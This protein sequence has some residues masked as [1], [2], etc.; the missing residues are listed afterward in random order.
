MNW[1]EYVMARRLIDEEM[2]GRLER[3]QDLA[4]LARESASQDILRSRGL[5]G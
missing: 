5:V 3:Q 4:D 2:R 1:R